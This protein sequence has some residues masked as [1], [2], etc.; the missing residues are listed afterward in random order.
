MILGNEPILLHC[1]HF[2]QQLILALDYM[3]HM[4]IAHR[5]LKLDS[6]LLKVGPCIAFHGVNYGSRITQCY[7]V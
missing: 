2:F 5:N 3:H 1:R 6:L 7:V 4:G